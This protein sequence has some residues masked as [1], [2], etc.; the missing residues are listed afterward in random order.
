MLFG[1]SRFHLAS[2][3]PCLKNGITRDDYTIG[4]RQKHYA[5]SLKH[6]ASMSYV[7]TLSFVAFGQTKNITSEACAAGQK[8]LASTKSAYRGGGRGEEGK[9]GTQ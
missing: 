6:T 4:V 9:G 5:I 3:E 2:R 8:H 7:T 1:E